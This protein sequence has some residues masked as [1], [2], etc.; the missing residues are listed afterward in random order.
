MTFTPIPHLSRGLNRDAIASLLMYCIDSSISPQLA[1]LDI[2]PE[3]HPSIE[4]VEP[5]DSTDKLAIAADLL[6]MLQRE[7]PP[8]AQFEDMR[9]SWLDSLFEPVDEGSSNG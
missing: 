6:Q 9:S 2:D 4:V 3:L 8:A 5:L 1:H 7:H